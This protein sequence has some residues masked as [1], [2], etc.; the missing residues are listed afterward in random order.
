MRIYLDESKRLWE[1]KIVFGWFITKHSHSYINNFILMKKEQYKIYN[2]FE[3]KGSKAWWK[4]FLEKIVKDNNFDILENSITGINIFWYF[5]DNLSGYKEIMWKIIEQ[6]KWY[7]IN[8]TRKIS[9]IADHVSFWKNTRKIELEIEQYLNERF[10]F[11]SKI[12]FT[13]VN[14][15]N[16]LWVQLADL[17]SY[18]LWRKY[19]EWENIEDFILN[20][21][22]NIDINKE[23]KA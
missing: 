12:T 5:K 17:I 8:Y 22:F 21:M 23:N 15:K 9:I 1:W 4:Y 2:D 18:T 6:H 11:Y 10:S 19:F 13:F 7:L 20:N 3:L 14:S 16:N